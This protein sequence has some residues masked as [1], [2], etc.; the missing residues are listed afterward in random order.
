MA[1][2][3]ASVPIARFVSTRLRRPWPQMT[4]APATALPDAGLGVLLPVLATTCALAA[5]AVP[6][7]MN[8]SGHAM[9]APAAALGAALFLGAV[10]AWRRRGR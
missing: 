10:A 3:L 2:Y 7:M 8:A 6:L 9:P 1:L 4:A 5:V